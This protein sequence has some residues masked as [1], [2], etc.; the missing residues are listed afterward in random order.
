MKKCTIL[1]I[2]KMVMTTKRFIERLSSY[3]KVRFKTLKLYFEP[4][5]KS[6]YYKCTIKHMK[7]DGSYSEEELL[8]LHYIDKHLTVGTF[9]TMLRKLSNLSIVVTPSGRYKKF[10]CIHMSINSKELIKQNAETKFEE[11]ISDVIEL[12]FTDNN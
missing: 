9:I 1:A 12:Y 11:L 7:E 10:V 6:V 2:R 3:L 4:M 5:F 8:N